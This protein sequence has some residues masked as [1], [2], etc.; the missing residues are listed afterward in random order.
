MIVHVDPAGEAP[1]P[2]PCVSI[3]V[4]NNDDICVA[5]YR[6]GDEISRWGRMSNIEKREVYTLMHERA[7]ELNPFL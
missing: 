4:L 7:K 2:S 1:L 5:C 6:T 3:C